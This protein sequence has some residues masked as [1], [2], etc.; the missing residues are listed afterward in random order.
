MQI[1]SF[2]ECTVLSSRRGYL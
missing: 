1:N 2:Q